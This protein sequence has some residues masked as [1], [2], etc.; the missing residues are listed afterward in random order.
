MQ[1][2]LW[3]LSKRRRRLRLLRDAAEVEA[4]WKRKAEEEIKKDWE[5]KKKDLE[6]ELKSVQK[7]IDK[8]TKFIEEEMS[9]QAKCSDPHKIK[10]LATSIRLASA[11][12]NKQLLLERELQEKLKLLAGKKPRGKGSV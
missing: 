8:R 10:D 7:Y 3:R 4:S 2:R 11:D 5:I 9:K 12:K 1:G 6:S